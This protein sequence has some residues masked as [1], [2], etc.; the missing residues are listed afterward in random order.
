MKIILATHNP[1]KCK[2]LEKAFKSYKIK[3]YTLRDLPE[4]EKIIEDGTTLE[5]NAFIK[6]RTVFNLTKIPTISDDTGL[7]VDSLNGIPGI[8][9]A[10]YAGENCSYSDN[11][12]KLLY[13]MKNIDDSLRNAT[14]KTV[15][16]YVSQDL[17]LV[18]DGGVKGFITRESKGDN[19]FGYD[20]IF[21][22][23]EYNKTFAEMDINEK[24]KCSHRAV[25]ISNLQSLFEKHNLLSKK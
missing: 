5:E 18:A 22:V 23:P 2:E 8:F 16:T 21:Y 13:N 19:G 15:V 3:I 24:Q 17:E 6:S 10:R 20:P 9:S 11:V 12:N 1:D 14:F 4:I 7:Y 25:A